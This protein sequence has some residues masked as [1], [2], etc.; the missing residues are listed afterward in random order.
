MRVVNLYQF[1]NTRSHAGWGS[2]GV[3]LKASLGQRLSAVFV[4]GSNRRCHLSESWMIGL[5]DI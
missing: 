3:L 5:D 4:K 2:A 1:L